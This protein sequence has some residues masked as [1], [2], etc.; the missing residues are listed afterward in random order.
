MKRNDRTRLAKLGI[1]S[2][3]ANAGILLARFFPS[4][5][6]DQLVSLNFKK[7]K[8]S[9]VMFSQAAHERGLTSD[10]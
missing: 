3:I 7:E 4:D 2:S 5:W 9:Y 6:I 10:H 8:L 1:L